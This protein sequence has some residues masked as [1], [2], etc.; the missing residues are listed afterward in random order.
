[1]DLLALDEVRRRLR[2]VGQ[3]YLGVRAIPVARI[4]GSLDRNADFDYPEL[5]EAS[6]WRVACAAPS[7][8]RRAS[9]CGAGSDYL[10]MWA[11]DEVANG[12][13]R[14]PPSLV[15]VTAQTSGCPASALRTV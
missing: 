7:C 8:A 5:L 4:V 6:A 1:M 14:M 11:T 2:I 3:S 12:T 13:L 15:A 10:G 9:R